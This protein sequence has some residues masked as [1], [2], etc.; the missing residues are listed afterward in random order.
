MTL[1][2]FKTELDPTV[3]Q[4]K[5]LA[6]HVGCARVAHNWALRRWK[7]LSDARGVTY[8]QCLYGHDPVRAQQALAIGTFLYALTSGEP[9]LV[10]KKRKFRAPIPPGPVADQ[11]P[12]AFWVHEQL[13]AEKNRPD[14][15]LAWLK[16]VSAFAVREAVGD[17]GRGYQ[18][19]FRRLKKHSVGDHSECQ[20]KRR[21]T[22]C[23]LGEPRFRKATERSWHADQGSAL[24]VSDGA[25]KIP[26]VGWVRVKERGYIPA[27]ENGSHKLVGGGKL[28]GLGCSEHGGR[29]YVAV[30]CDVHEKPPKRRIGGTVGVDTG[31]LY[32]AVTS[33]GLR[34][35]GLETDKKL[36]ALERRRKLWERRMARRWR[37]PA[38]L[39][40]PAHP[41]GAVIAAQSA[42]WHEAR[43]EVA[44]YHRRVVEVRNDRVGKA[45]AAI[46][47]T[48]A[49]RVV[50]RGQPV[51]RMLARDGSDADRTRNALAPR[52]H[53]ARMGD[54]AS[55]LEYKM[56]W[57]GGECVRAPSEYPSTRRCH[58]CG[59]VRD[60]DP[61]YPTW[62]C[63]GCGAVLDRELNS[64]LNLKDYGAT[65]EP[66][67]PERPE[68]KKAVAAE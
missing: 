64:A 63:D 34:F 41:R 11:L 38:E 28:C 32:L 48:G 45:V 9:V 44:K 65:G 21:G 56:K 20:P 23:S 19:F 54:L 61:G 18:A 47:R 67:E 24:R 27:T 68:P 51:T 60:S 26:S 15:D 25:V 10:R 33:T 6:R 2:A 13:T 30:R 42:G 7:Q 14:S 39:G 12:S 36:V 52:I 37:T 58:A 62:I 59:H 50:V 5:A 1:K 35:P 17:V 49:E 16:E 8:L 66:V 29:W 3:E 31:V 40:L 46:L 4:R 53:A 22:G 57:L 43:R 55:R